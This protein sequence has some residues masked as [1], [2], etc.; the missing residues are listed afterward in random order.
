M[1]KKREQ[2][3]WKLPGTR[4]F[5]WRL[6]IFVLL[7]YVV[8]PW[9]INILAQSRN[10]A[11][12]FNGLYSTTFSLV[13]VIVFVLA[14]RH[15][16]PKMKFGW[17]WMQAVAFLVISAA[18][19]LIYAHITFG[20]IGFGLSYPTLYIFF[21]G[22]LY[23]LG[24][25]FLAFAFFQ[26]QFFMRFFRKF[27]IALTIAI[28]YFVIALVLRQLWHFFS[29]TVMHSS[30][31][32]LNILGISNSI[33][34]EAGKAP[35]FTVGTFSAYIGSPC[36]G[37]DG[38][39]MFSGLYAFIGLLDWHRINKKRLLILFPLGLIGM[40]AM[41]IIRI[42]TLMLVGA[43]WSPKLALSLF[44]NNAGWILFVSY[45]LVLM[46]FAYPWLTNGGK[47]GAKVQ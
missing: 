42:F 18:H 31:F 12:R 45:F 26:L 25:I 37:V 33:V 8:V 10:P 35:L 41:S 32:L 2:S 14:I 44:H 16:I 36:S 43:K 39:I 46:Y 29:G 13:V 17:S 38:L 23:A 6:A 20:Q 1:K 47:N 30:A 7:A 5:A 4:Q 28:P 40:F 22:M 27:I 19:L 21:T 11:Y 15:E 24:L 9:L 34:Q 3:V